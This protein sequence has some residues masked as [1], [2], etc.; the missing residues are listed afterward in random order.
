MRVF[1]AGFRNAA[2]RNAT[3]EFLRDKKCCVL[4]TQP[5]DAAT[6]L[7]ALRKEMETTSIFTQRRRRTQP[8]RAAFTFNQWLQHCG[9][10]EFRCAKCL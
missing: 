8:I 3:Q 9:I 10:G 6:A 7:A 5:A 1:H 2:Q 4:F